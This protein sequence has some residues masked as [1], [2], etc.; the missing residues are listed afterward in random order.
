MSK[1]SEGTRCP[2]CL[3][4]PQ[5][6]LIDPHLPPDRRLSYP[7]W[8]ELCS[9]LLPPWSS[10]ARKWVGYALSEL[11]YGLALGARMKPARSQ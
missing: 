10:R 11:S 5:D 8:L 3:S 1:V 7:P 9:R 6:Q 4:R 2:K